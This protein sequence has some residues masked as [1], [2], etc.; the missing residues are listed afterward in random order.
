VG[1]TSS[2]VPTEV[3][4]ILN[5]LRRYAF[6]RNQLIIDRLNRYLSPVNVEYE[7][8]VVPLT[9]SGNATER[10]IV[11]AYL[12]VAQR[13]QSDLPFYWAQKLDLPGAQ[14]AETM[15]DRGKFINL[16]R[17]KLMK[18][19]SIG[20][21]EPTPDTFPTIQDINRLILSCG[22]IPCVAWLDGT[23]QGEEAIGEL[24]E[25]LMRQGA[26]V[27]NIIPDRNWNLVDEKVRKQKL[28]KL[29]EIVRVAHE[30]GLPLHTGTE[31][32]NYGQR[33][34]DDFDAPALKPIRQAALDGA[35]FI[36][37]HTA[38]QLALGLG[39][40]SSW[41]KAYLPNRL[42]RK[43]FYTRMGSQIPPGS[44][45]IKTLQSL[46]SH[47]DPAQFLSIL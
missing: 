47:A 31:M 18:Q 2:Q 6:Q 39:Y 35:H 10:H 41:A 5:N 4:H 1:F 24:L 12:L 28:T 3:R 22:A 16:I 21:I 7:G 17:T 20:Y 40:E 15:R 30:L 13:T 29:Y 26:S 25:L 43:Q 14:V 27:V 11:Q 36:F 19:G 37:G 23:S 32:N 45:G 9:P 44:Q 33:L 42:E 8:D 38:M 34:I 46:S